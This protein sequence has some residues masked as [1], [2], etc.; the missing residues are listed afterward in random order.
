MFSCTFSQVRL[1]HQCTSYYCSQYYGVSQKTPCTILQYPW[2]SPL[3]KIS[4]PMVQI[5]FVCC[6]HN[7]IGCP[8]KHLSLLC[9]FGPE[10]V[11]AVTELLP[12]ERS[13]QKFIRF[14]CF[15]W[16]KL[17]GWSK[18]PTWSRSQRILFEAAKILNKLVIGL[19]VGDSKQGE[20]VSSIQD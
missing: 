17:T 11:L 5:A 7:I 3:L 19:T 15:A 6:F 18:E 16:Y 2:I 13:L 14:C 8:K 9:L 12:G 1:S 10:E 4:L 20:V